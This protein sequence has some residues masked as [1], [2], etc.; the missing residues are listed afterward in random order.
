MKLMTKYEII[1]GDTSPLFS[2]I[3]GIRRAEFKQINDLNL[4]IIRNIMDFSGNEPCHIRLVPGGF[5]DIDTLR[6]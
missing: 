4:P 5:A 3:P 2:Y 6:R 1:A